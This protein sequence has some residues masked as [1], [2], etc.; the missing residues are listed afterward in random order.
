[1]NDRLVEQI[2]LSCPICNRKHLVEKRIRDTQALFKGQVIDYLEQYFICS[3]TDNEENEFV[4]AKQLDENLLNVR[5]S[6]RTIKG[7]LT[8]TEIAS[9]RSSYGLTQNE[10][11]ALL[12][13]GEVTIT[14]YESKT[15]QDETYDSL[16]RMIY[17]NPMM[18]FEYLEKHKDRFR[19]ERYV[20][21]RK[22]IVEK[23]KNEGNVFLKKQEIK[24]LY[25]KYE[26]LSDLNGYK[27]IDID[28]LG[29]VLAYFATNISSLFKVKLMKLLWYADT[30]HY[31]RYGRSM[32]G[33]VYE[34]MTFGALPIGFNEIM[35]LPTINVVEEMIYEDLAYRVLPVLQISDDLFTTDE[36]DV[37]EL[38][39]TK[40]K[41]YKSRQIV[42]YMHSEKAYIATKEHE[43]IPYSMA[44]DL[45]ELL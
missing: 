12:G 28:K 16:M 40:F 39:V 43:I 31:K 26:N 24:N 18:A 44:K 37:L 34:H 5:D 4:P 13:W 21:T 25:L 17:E 6:Y 23:V 27:V 22:L 3:E 15:I 45:R 42:D 9:I 7:L 38:V 14:R 8:S 11:A 29:T 19:D 1:M 20:I 2:E 32:T 36:R 10:F 41:D 33:L 35:S 30:I